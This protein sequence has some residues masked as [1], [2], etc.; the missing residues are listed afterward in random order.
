MTK[1]MTLHDRIVEVLHNHKSGIDIKAIREQLGLEAGEHQH[2]DRRVRDLDAQY[3]IE[4]IR[5]GS[6]IL[7]KLIG[8]K[9]QSLD[10]VAIS[11]TVRAKILYRDAA[12]CQLCGRSVATDRVK[13]HIDHKMPREWGGKTEEDNLWT[14]CSECNEGK[15]NFFA[16]ITDEDVRAAMMH[17]SVHIRI[18][19]LLK[20]KAGQPVPKELL[21][22]VANTH[23]DWEKR[24]REL[25][26]LG[27]NYTFKK[28]KD[29]QSGKT[30]VYF[31][32]HEWLP[33]PP[34][35]AQ[36]IRDAERTKGKKR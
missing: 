32:L 13:L 3:D 22:L 19:E 16:S 11:K 8:P 14:L 25:R 7:Y 2:L 4:R 17:K 24:L 26:E 15:K 21:H 34:N 35:P 30:K 10:T 20:S 5:A 12:T 33:W 28:E 6:E 23:D 18:G 29:L 9:A 27:W 31:I 36:A 1:R